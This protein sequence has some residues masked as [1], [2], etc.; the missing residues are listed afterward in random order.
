MGVLGFQI[1]TLFLNGVC[2][3][4][5]YIVDFS[6]FATSQWEAPSLKTAVIAIGGNALLRS[7]EKPTQENQMRN[8]AQTARGLADLIE[9]GYD[10][11]L[12]HGNGPQ[13]GDILLRNE[14]AKGEIPP[15]GMDVCDAESQGQIGYML[16]Q[17]LTSEFLARNLEKVAVS[18]ITQVIVDEND[19]AF[20]NPTKPIGKYFS[21]QESRLLEKEKGWVMMHDKKRG[22]WRRVVPSPDPIGIVEYK[23]VRRLVFGGEHQAEVVIACGGGG[24]PVVKRDNHY[25]GVEAVVDKD[26]AASMLAVSIKERLFVMATDVDHVFLDFGT[27]NQRPF[28]SSTKSEIKKLYSE[29]QFPPGTMGPKILAAIRF[30]EGGGEEVIICS[31]NNL[32]KAI[33][34][35]AGTHIYRDA[36]RA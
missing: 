25:V 20:K 36:I 27:I 14:I 3:N 26:L 15:M 29:G 4:S 2:R 1:N 22:G 31:L 24:I 17:A 13:V 32:V 33:E 18:L 34:E 19:P 6:M 12:T 23:P 9:R 5:S 8:V 16:Q 30:L 28:M 21:A 35:G 10:I 11:V 7:G